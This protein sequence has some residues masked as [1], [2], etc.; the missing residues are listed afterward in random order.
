MDAIDSGGLRLFDM[1]CHPAFADDP[2]AFCGQAGAAGV[3][4]FANTTCLDEYERWAPTI[5]RCGNARVGVG[6]HPW[7]VHDGRAPEADLVR[8]LEAVAATRFIG[9]VGLDFAPRH[10]T[11]RERQ[12]RCFTR[13]IDACAAQG[14]KLVSVH[15][16]RSA[17]AVLDVLERSG[18]LMGNT[19]II[20]W[21][22]GTS[23]ELTRARDLGCYFSVGMRMLQTR[24][25]RAYAR[26]IPSQRLLLET[27]LPAEQGDGM[28]GGQLA[29]ELD[30]TLVQLAG[31]RQCDADELRATIATTSSILINS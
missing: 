23:D 18:F 24:R 1:H 5:A 9:E 31:I 6:M 19:A 21:F 13:I 2:Q 8:I 10:E 27:D 25:G 12:M 14:G 7:W 16:V 20:H 4:L 28:R 3:G 11:S 22:S 29:S 15:A 26:A 30:E 17:S